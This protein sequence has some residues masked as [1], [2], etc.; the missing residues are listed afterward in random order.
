MSNKVIKSRKN[1]QSFYFNEESIEVL[2]FSWMDQNTILKYI[3]FSVHF[4]DS[5][6]LNKDRSRNIVSLCTL[7]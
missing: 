2:V 7:I 6:T 4:H 5:A 1:V 3:S